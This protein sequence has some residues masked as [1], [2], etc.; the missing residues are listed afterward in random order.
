MI[1]FT[2]NNS[3]VSSCN[4]LSKRDALRLSLHLSRGQPPATNPY[5]VCSWTSWASALCRRFSSSSEYISCGSLPASEY[6]SCP[7]W[8][9]LQDSNR[10]MNSS[11]KQQR[12]TCISETNTVI[13]LLSYFIIFTQRFVHFSGAYLLP[14]SHSKH[15]YNAANCCK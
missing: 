15:Q 14:I 2:F 8:L 1:P 5:S 10:S 9:S 3:S 6:D 11:I 4:I 7:T 13:L 12:S